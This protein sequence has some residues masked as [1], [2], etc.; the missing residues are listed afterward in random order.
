MQRDRRDVANRKSVAIVEEP[1]KFRAIACEL[2]PN[3]ED[4]SEHVLDRDDLAPNSE[5]PAQFLLD[6]WRGR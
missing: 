6:V 5:L 4:L 3:V 2:G 1:V